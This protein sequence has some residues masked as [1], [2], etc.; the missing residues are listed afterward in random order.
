MQ[1]GQYTLLEQLPAG[2]YRAIWR[3]RDEHSG[4]EVALKQLALANPDR[5]PA[6]RQLG[7]ALARVQHP[8]LAQPGEPVVNAD[9]LWLV[10]EWITGASLEAALSAGAGLTRSQALGVLHRTLEGLAEAHRHGV[11][12]GSVSPGTIMITTQGEPKLVDFGA[13]LGEPDAAGMGAYASPEA[14]A[15]HRLTPAAD[16]F[17]AATVAA[18]ILKRFGSLSGEVLETLRRATSTDPDQRQADAWVLLNELEQAGDRTYGAGWWTTQGIADVMTSTGATLGDADRPAL[19][20]SRASLMVAGVGI[21]MLA[22]MAAGAY[23]ITS[24]KTATIIGQPP[25][26]STVGGQWP[27][28]GQATQ[29]PT[30]KPAPRGLNGVYS[31]QTVITKTNWPGT[32]VGTKQKNSWTARTTCVGNTCASV[33]T[34]KSGSTF[35]LNNA[36]DSWTTRTTSQAQCV[37]TRTGRSTGKQVPVRFTRKLRVAARSGDLVTKITGTARSAQLKKCRNQRTPLVYQ[38]WKMTITFVKS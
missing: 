11:V 26:P 21:A 17:S 29:P 9:G 36:A 18:E 32:K 35:S 37:D 38:E 4:H 10:E 30:P 31:Y 19:M 5:R 1:I 25:A 14:L 16:V 34:P 12:H 20:S 6:I 7:A 27:G 3:A 28:G 24:H 8:N 23:A 13:W 2:R 15:G 33:V 22:V